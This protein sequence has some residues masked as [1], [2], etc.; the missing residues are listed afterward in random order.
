MHDRIRMKNRIDHFR[1]ILINSSQVKIT[2]NLLFVASLF[3]R[4]PEDCAYARL[5]I[6]N[7]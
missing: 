2:E 4:L 5:I 7:P 3:N 1:L 6:Q